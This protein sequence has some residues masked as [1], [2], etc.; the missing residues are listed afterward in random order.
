VTDTGHLLERQSMKWWSLRDDATETVTYHQR[1]KT[2]MDTGMSCGWTS[3]PSIL[4]YKHVVQKDDSGLSKQVMHCEL[5]TIKW[6]TGRTRKNW[7]DII[8]QDL[9]DI[10][11]CCEEVQECCVDRED[12]RPCV[13]Q[14]VF[15][16]AWTNDQRHYGK[17]TS[18]T[19]G[20]LNDSTRIGL[21]L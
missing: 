19:T 2:E 3:R 8:R 18:L 11:M 21:T 7:I 10:D 9:Q 6:R 14:C 12:W 15:D 4:F 5:N 13:T 20:N 1:Q 16:T 17:G